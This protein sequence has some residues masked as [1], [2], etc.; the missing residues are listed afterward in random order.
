MRSVLFIDG[1]NFLKKVREVFRAHGQS[2][3]SWDGYDFDGLITTAL[4]GV[5]VDERRFYAAKLHEHPSTLEQSRILI[6]KQRNLKRKLE[7]FGFQFIISGHV[8][9]HEESIDGKRMVFFR[10]KGVDVRI[11]VDMAT[12][13][14][15]RRMGLAIIASSDSDLQPAIGEIR[16]R[17]VQ[18]LYLGFER[19]PNKGMTYTT[20]RTI[21]IR[22]AEVF[23]FAATPLVP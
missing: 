17:D 10:E 23:R 13:A 21:L 22:D 11:A 19:S 16:R 18:C 15:D 2:G 6:E 5:V 9:A 4:Q 20:N 14:C 8:R 7:G 3:P 12:M 1:E